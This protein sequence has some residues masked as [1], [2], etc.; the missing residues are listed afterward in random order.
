MYNI[1]SVYIIYYNQ[2]LTF[3]FLLLF[4]FG[5]KGILFIVSS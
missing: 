2:K 4:P 5:I 1:L 3:T